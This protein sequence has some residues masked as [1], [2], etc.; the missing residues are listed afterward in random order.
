MQKKPI[1]HKITIGLALLGLLTANIVFLPQVFATTYTTKASVILTNMNASAAGPAILVFTPANTGTALTLTMGGGSVATTQTVSNSYNG[2]NCTAI[3]GATANVPGAPAASGSGTTITFSGITAYTSGTSYCVVLTSSTAVTNPTAG[4]EAATLTAGTD[5]A[6]ALQVDIISNDQVVVSATV[7]ASYTL[8][9]SG[10]T[11]SLGTLASGS[12]STS[13]GVTATVNTNA[14]NGWF[15]FG[16]D[17]NT[18]LTSA[19]Q[20]KTIASTTPGSNT[21]LS[22][23]TEGYVTGL[24]SAGITQ[25]G[26]VGV[27]SATTAYTAAATTGRGSGLNTSENTLASSTGTASGAIVTVKE[28]AAIT[29]LTPAAADYSDTITLVGAGSF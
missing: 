22:A 29:A 28:Y 24:P 14:K 25:G 9:L 19:S 11:D 20:S 18:G 26:G 17:S 6:D 13:T 3:T 8:A 5:A 27:T 4:T 23:G 1:L 2:T 21:T 16:S 7:P 10:N 15:L 12:V